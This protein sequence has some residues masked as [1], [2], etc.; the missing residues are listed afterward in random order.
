MVRAQLDEAR[1]R[2]EEADFD[3]ALAALAR[4]ERG[5]DLDADGVI[6]LF[7]LRALVHLGM[8]DQ[9]AMREDVRALILLRPGV[10]LDE[11]TP[12][13]VR[14][15]A[16]AIRGELAP[17]RVEATLEPTD[18]G[19]RIDAAVSGDVAEL[20]RAVRV[21]TRVAGGSWLTGAPPVSLDV[22][23]GAQLAYR[24]EAIGPGGAVIAE[25]GTA[26]DPRTWSSSAAVSDDGG[27]SPWVLIGIGGA[28]AVGLGVVLAVVL[29]SG[30]SQN[31]NTQPTLPMA[32]S[33]VP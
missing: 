15:A 2:Y 25:D 22:P 29:T 10:E 28:L 9:D 5:S 12:P 23:G 30:G 18:E 13:E 4:A 7:R 14:E 20:V 16:D 17:L 1:A 6:E 8:G 3:S 24:A 31:D 26:A 21:H 11:T 33:Y 27:G 19:A 32:L